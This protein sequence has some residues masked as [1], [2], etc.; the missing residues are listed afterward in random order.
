MSVYKPIHAQVRQ[1][2]GQV[3]RRL[4]AQTAARG[5]AVC[6][7]V[8]LAGTILAVLGANAWRFSDSATGTASAL[9]WLALLGALAWFLFRPLFRRTSDSRIARFIEEK[10]PE[11]KDRLVTAIDMQERSA[12][13][14]SARV[15]S[16]LVAEDALRR[17]PAAPAEN[18]IDSRRIFRPLIWATGSVAIILLLGLFGPG[19]FRY[20]T[21]ALWVGWVQAKT[22][23]LYQI[24]VTPG[25]ITV[26]R[27]TDQEITAEPVGFLPQQMRLFVQY[28]KNADWESAPMMSSERG[29]NFHL[30][31]MNVQQ[32]IDYYVESNS[33][34]SPQHTISVIAVP[35]IDRLEVRYHFPAYAGLP[36]KV[37]QSGGDIIGLKDTEIT[38]TV[39]TDAPSPGGRLSL[40]DNS[41]IE[42]SKTGNLELQA[43]WT[44]SQDTLYHV[45]LQDPRGREARASEEYLMQAISDFAPTVKLTRPGRDLQPTPVEEVVVGFEGQDDVRLADLSLHYSVNG[46]AAQ[47]VPLI[48]K[49]GGQQAS[50]THLL[51][52]EEYS[53]APGDLIT[54]Y[55]TAKDAAANTA[56]TDMFFLQVRPFERSY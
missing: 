38:L 2:L 25:N 6:G 35:R 19:I 16:E 22:T 51:A 44:L 45:R 52:L 49:S 28:E 4:Q 20:G 30:L 37:E 11:F 42:L 41:S 47:T 12:T 32:Q 43:K 33:V 26:G 55:G 1:Y 27:N 5:L 24:R 46:G 23:P 18:L 29:G 39:H 53:L 50:A 7:V 14:P 34:R 10:H 54:Y 36:D 21:K 40:D 9:L 17:T 3:R 48:S 13:D 56:T 8:A 15:F 31:L